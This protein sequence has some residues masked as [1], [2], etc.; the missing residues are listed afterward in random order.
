MYILFILANYW[1]NVLNEI[2]DI[3]N[4][5]I[6]WSIFSVYDQQNLSVWLYVVQ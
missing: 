5:I 4:L 6:N 3:W 2:W 1:N